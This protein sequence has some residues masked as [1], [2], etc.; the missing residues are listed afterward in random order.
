MKKNII[1]L[2]LDKQAVNRGFYL[3]QVE[4]FSFLKYLNTECLFHLLF[5]SKNL[6]GGTFGLLKN[7]RKRDKK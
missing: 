2:F 7:E 3:E 1:F 5:F 6:K 4:N